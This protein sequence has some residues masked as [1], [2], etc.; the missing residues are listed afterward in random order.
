MA[1]FDITNCDFYIVIKQLL[2]TK[3]KRVDLNRGDYVCRMGEKTSKFGVVVSGALKYSFTTSNGNER[4]ISFA[5]IGDLVGSYCA[6]RSNSPSLIDI[7]A[8]ESTVIYQ[9]PIEQIDA[10]IGLERRVKLSEA[11]C[12]QA[13]K[14]A[15]ENYC[16][17]ARERYVSLTLRF[18]DIHNRMT[19]RTI[20]SYLGVTP[21]SLSR[22]R[23]RLLTAE[24]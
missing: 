18:P 15:V 11:V 10:A 17:S 20:A 3:G 2:L 23:K 24:L 22:L 8:I 5:F 14:S 12:N 13:L 4:I 21:E 7:V 1:F 6:M 19:N 16:K 9:L